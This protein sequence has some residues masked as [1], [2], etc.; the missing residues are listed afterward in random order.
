MSPIVHAILN[1]SERVYNITL[2]DICDCTAVLARLWNK[3]YSNTT[4][5]STISITGPATTMIAT[6]TVNVFTSVSGVSA[7]EHWI[8]DQLIPCLVPD[9]VD[10]I[11][12]IWIS[13]AEDMKSIDETSSASNDKS[14]SSEYHKHNISDFKFRDNF[15]DNKRY[16]TRMPWLDG[17]DNTSTGASDVHLVPSIQAMIRA[18]KL[19][20]GSFVAFVPKPNLNCDPSV[21]DAP[22]QS[23]AASIGVA[24]VSDVLGMTTDGSISVSLVPSPSVKCQ[25]LSEKKNRMKL[26]NLLPGTSMDLHILPHI[27][28][29]SPSL[30]IFIL[31]KPCP[32]SNITTLCVGKHQG[33]QSSTVGII[34]Q[35]TL[36]ELYILQQLH[37]T[38]KE[39][40]HAC[41]GLP[42]GLACDC[43]SND[44]ENGG[45]DEGKGDNVFESERKEGE[46]KMGD[47][48]ALS[49]GDDAFFTSHTTTTTATTTTTISSTIV[50]K[51]NNNGSSSSYGDDYRRQNYYEQSSPRN[52]KMRLK[53]APLTFIVMPSSQIHIP[54]QSLLNKMSK[55]KYEFGSSYLHLQSLC[56]D[57]I[58]AISHCVSSGVY[59]KWIGIE[60]CYISDKGRLVIAGLSGA[61]SSYTNTEFTKPVCEILKSYEKHKYKNEHGESLSRNEADLS[62]L[63]HLPTTAPE[64]VCGAVAST[65]SSIWVAGIL[66]AVILI[67]KSPIKAGV[68]RKKH[69]QYI[70]KI[71][72][73]PSRENCSK[74]YSKYPLMQNIGILVDN[75]GTMIETRSRLRKTL[76]TAI[77]KN[78][79]EYYDRYSSGWMDK[80]LIEP[81][82]LNPSDRP[83]LQDFLGCSFISN[84]GSCREV[85][86]HSLLIQLGLGVEE[87]T[88]ALV[89]ELGVK[90]PREN[91]TQSSTCHKKRRF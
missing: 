50:K 89:S 52:D 57:I 60:E 11:L 10:M 12:S 2:D 63:P 43:S 14:I 46:K 88:S 45:E 83:S 74:E 55:S 3:I 8:L 67:G 18:R 9:M 71:L 66:C 20:K 17:E 78:M 29:P 28:N 85:E 48:N 40:A 5:S 33:I 68:S 24:H 39:G 30:I 58:H 41:F 51:N 90:K 44:T 76:L 81:L 32:N 65:T 82:S 23:A 35:D 49:M 42:V 26:I 47:F 31:S 19:T 36:S 61:V 6:T 16:R 53:K 64:I 13:V 21:T 70:Y 34:S 59:M 38:C 27:G 77:T 72:G 86:A 84:S 54:L 37:Y 73:T 56:R 79:V 7:P 15:T 4:N 91:D 22:V 1:V 69:M 80:L 75:D 87:S 62:E 25:K